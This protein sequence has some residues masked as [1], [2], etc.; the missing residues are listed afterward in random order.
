MQP[1]KNKKKG[2]FSKQPPLKIYMQY[3]K[4]LPSKR[5]VN[6]KNLNVTHP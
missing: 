4:N 6:I 3:T 2:I 5:E 1:A